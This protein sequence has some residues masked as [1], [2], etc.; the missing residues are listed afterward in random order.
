MS[1]N[2]S[3]R[4]A[5]LRVEHYLSQEQLANTIGVSRQA[6]SKWERGEST[7]DTDNLIALADEY[8][9]SLD[10]LIRGE[11][12]EVAE[13]L[14]DEAS[15]EEE[16]MNDA[17]MADEEPEEEAAAEPVD[18]GEELVP[19]GSAHEESPGPEPVEQTAKLPSVVDSYEHTSGGQDPF[20][21]QYQAPPSAGPVPPYPTSAE[22]K[23]RHG[24]LKWLGIA[25]LVL[26]LVGPTSCMLGLVNYAFIPTSNG[27]A[28][29][30]TLSQSFDAVS[31]N[32]ISIDWTAG[33]VEVVVVN[34]AV[35]DE[36]TV[37]EESPSGWRSAPHMVVEREAG[38]LSIWYGGQTGG[39]LSCAFSQGKHLTVAIPRSCAER[40]GLFSV[41]GASGEYHVSGITCEQFVV[42]LSSGEFEASDVTTDDLAVELSSGGVTFDGAVRSSLMLD[43]ASGIVDVSSDAVPKTGDIDVASGAVAVRLPADA[44]F[45][46]TVD[47]S[48]GDF[49]CD[50]PTTRS[51]NR[52]IAGDGSM[53][54]NIDL[55]SGEVYL[56][57]L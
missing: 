20:R 39:L 4:L 57:Q 48:S 5:R 25:A 45:T 17:S 19:E 34:D 44:G 41:D 30:T 47:A 9:I 8:G 3:Q 55:S 16:S 11:R 46:A 49:D 38:M 10:G 28:D 32:D 43:V 14:V 12:L 24:W 37:S 36:I 15:G 53:D 21:N 54:L 2:L 42:D 23:K 33:V 51:G 29:G 1:E 40:L 50:Y 13:D 26:L 7:P 6:V 22:P 31:I 27:T 56:T 18:A 52:Y 35:S